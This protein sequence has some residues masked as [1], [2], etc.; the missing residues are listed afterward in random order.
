M[1]SLHFFTVNKHY[2]KERRLFHRG[3]AIAFV[4]LKRSHFSL[5][6]ERCKYTH[7]WNWNTI[8]DKLIYQMIR[9]WPKSKWSLAQNSR[10]NYMQM[11]LVVSVVFFVSIH[12]FFVVAT[13]VFVVCGGV[14][15]CVFQNIC[16]HTLAIKPN[17][18]KW[19]SS[20]W[21]SFCRK[22][23]ALEMVAVENGGNSLGFQIFSWNSTYFIWKRSNS[24]FL[25]LKFPV[26]RKR[27]EFPPKNS[28]KYD[29]KALLITNFQEPNRH[30]NKR[31]WSKFIVMQCLFLHAKWKKCGIAWKTW[32]S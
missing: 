10:A 8:N 32:N 26:R 7:C 19:M 15:P 9:N 25:I 30:K 2:L 1:N 5:W 27:P 16:S 31:G 24:F 13:F 4:P 23:V 18:E 6:I 12:S 29:S 17:L 20:E 11:S 22:V 3:N 21:I 28:R 14:W